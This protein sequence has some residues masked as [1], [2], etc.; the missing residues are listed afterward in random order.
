MFDVLLESRPP[1]ERLALSRGSVA[2]LT[3]HLIIIGFIAATAGGGALY[4]AGPIERA[5][6][7]A[8]FR[9]EPKTAAVEQLAFASG[10]DGRGQF[11]GIDGLEGTDALLERGG[12]G[13]GSAA[14][15][16]GSAFKALSAIPSPNA[17]VA[18]AFM[19]FDVDS[20]AE[21]AADAEVPPYPGSLLR[22]GIEGL[23]MVQFVVD[24]TGMV[25]LRS[26]K[27]IRATHPLFTLSVYS[28]LSRMRYRPASIGGRP[29]RQLVQQEFRF[30]IVPAEKP[31]M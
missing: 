4:L 7:L 25:D 21:R 6:F 19:E 31:A 11:E 5:I 15:G 2:S 8:P 23:T 18:S 1:R 13:A 16:D 27:E 29:V 10:V 24:S 3:T 14:A 30:R 22:Q 26:F 17:N 28:A 20:A 9:K 12:R